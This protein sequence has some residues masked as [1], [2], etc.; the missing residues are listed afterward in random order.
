MSLSEATI[1]SY[2]C[3][4]SKLSKSGW[5]TAESLQTNSADVI[6]HILAKTV[7]PTTKKLYLCACMWL[8]RSEAPLADVTPYQNTL[9]EMFKVTKETE[10]NQ[11]LRATQQDYTNWPD[12]L[13]LRDKA[14]ELFGEI[15]PKYIIYCLYTLQP[16]VRA[17]YVDM[18]VVY[19]WE[20]VGQYLNSGDKNVCIH[21]DTETHWLFQSYK[22]AKT[23]GAVT[24]K[25]PQ[26]IHDILKP[27]LRGKPDYLL[28]QKN[29]S[30][31]ANYISA[32]FQ[33][34]LNKKI[35]LTILRRSYITDW[36]NK[37]RKITE[38]QEMARRMLH[39]KNLQEQYA[40]FDSS[41]SDGDV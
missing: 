28:P 14:K 1:K 41:S 37:P 36:L 17:D 15:H 34:L 35:T 30:A 2:N 7:Q 25:A 16:P 4:L 11:E 39:S 21:T 24:L 40:V 13:A 31:L 18:P 10:T 22:T 23:Y 8:I 6:A 20:N 3:C 32:I 27:Y 9:S 12:I 29:A 5:K 26:E 33:A 19:N 38:K